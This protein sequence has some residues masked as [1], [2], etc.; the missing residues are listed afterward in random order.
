MEPYSTLE[1]HHDQARDGAAS[2]PRPPVYSQLPE[3]VPIEKQTSGIPEFEQHQKEYIPSYNVAPEVVTTQHHEDAVPE[4]EA[5]KQTIDEDLDKK[6]PERKICGVRRRTFFIVLALALVVIGGAV[7]GGVAGALSTRKNSSSATS[8]NVM[9]ISSLSASNWTDPKGYTHR[10]VFFQDTYNSIIARRWES[11]NKTWVTSN[12]TLVMANSATPLA[13]ASGTALASAT[14][15]WPGSYTVQLW[16]LDE[17]YLIRS[18]FSDQPGTLPD[19][20]KNDLLSNA[21]IQAYSGS[22][23]AATWRRCAVKGCV[24]GWSVAYQSTDGAIKVTNHTNWLTSTGALNANQVAANTSLALLP[25]YR[26]NQSSLGLVSQSYTSSSVGSMQ[27]N[28]YGD[29]WETYVGEI[30]SGIPLPASSQ[31]SAVTKWNTWDKNL[32]YTLSADGTMKGVWWTYG[33]HNALPNIA[34]DGGPNT[35][36]SAI[37][38]TTDAMFYGLSNDEILEY[39]IDSSDPS[40]LHF[41]G[42]VYP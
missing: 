40:T 17:Q 10:V 35:N 8:V 1:V 33:N 27:V 37:A 9:D 39:T 29:S 42:K 36:F 32:C 41:V 11:Q 21:D 19:L 26:G 12:I 15:D 23:L 30:I 24:G 31:H 28:R 34:F 22:K 38:M 3:A 5:A 16:F 6:A 4:N 7:V 25:Q 2:D 14:L 20:W 18:T 13:P